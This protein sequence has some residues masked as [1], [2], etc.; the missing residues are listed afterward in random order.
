MASNRETARL[1]KARP[2]RQMRYGQWEALD[3]L[4]KG[5]QGRVYRALDTKVVDVKGAIVPQILRGVREVGQIGSPEESR[6]RVLR[7]LRAIE[8]YIRRDD[9]KH[10]GALK[11]LHPE[12]RDDPKAKGRMEREVRVLRDQH[13]PHIV[14]ILDSSVS[15]GWFVTE[16][17]PLGSLAKHP[18]RFRRQ[19]IEAL[20]AL[21]PLVEAVAALHAQ[22]ITHRD[23][24]PK[25]IFV[26]SEGLVLGDFGLVY[27]SGYGADRLPSTYENVGSRDWMPPWEMG[28]FQEEP[29]PA[30]DV[31]SLAKVL[32]AMVSGRHILQLWYFRQP[33][34]DLEEQFPGDSSMA[35][36]NDL[37]AKCIVQHEAEC[38]PSAPELINAIDESLALLRRTPI[39]TQKRERGPLTEADRERL[40]DALR[41]SQEGEAVTARTVE[42]LK[43]VQAMVA[44]YAIEE[45]HLFDL[46][47]EGREDRRIRRAQV[48]AAQWTE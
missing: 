37:L 8:G 20:V 48:M 36:L 24:A 42:A 30:F 38:L 28:A 4:G 11:V 15:A 7:F 40:V 25:N 27:Q 21:C 19:P 23:I 47:P 44:K 17:F 41:E 43:D 13:H 2:S 31:F 33:K 26:G 5:G 46:I 10:C 14:T 9:P 12:I 34:F 6:E 1:E 18:T 32:W 16:Y 22:G 45:R 3:E 39:A 29:S 35:I